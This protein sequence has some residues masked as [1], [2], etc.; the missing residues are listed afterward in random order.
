M[1]IAAPVLARY[2]KVKAKNFGKLPRWHLGA[3]GEAF[4]FIDEITVH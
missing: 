3:G 2:V 4:I 1:F